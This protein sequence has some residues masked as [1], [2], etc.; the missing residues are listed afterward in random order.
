MGI[1]GGGQL[2]RMMHA[3]SIGLGINVR[4]LAEAPDTSAATVVHDVTV[5]DY[6]D[7]VT[8]RSFAGRLRCGDLRP[9]ACAHRAAAGS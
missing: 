2:A 6:T 5:G 8:V 9:R 1:I 7:P 4:L 3:A